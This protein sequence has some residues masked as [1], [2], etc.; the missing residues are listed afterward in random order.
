LPTEPENPRS[1]ALQSGRPGA[2]P[3]EELTRDELERQAFRAV[4]DG[5]TARLEAIRN[6]L[7]RRKVKGSALARFGEPE[8]ES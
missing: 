3:L 2:G 4:T 5:D 1:G 7:H 8:L 6:E